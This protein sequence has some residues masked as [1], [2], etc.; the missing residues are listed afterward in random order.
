M[1]LLEL[2]SEKLDAAMND[3]TFSAEHKKRVIEVTQILEQFENFVSI[4]DKNT[5]YDT[6]NNYKMDYRNKINKPFSD[7]GHKDWRTFKHPKQD[8]DQRDVKKN[9]EGNWRTLK[10]DSNVAA[11]IFTRYNKQTSSSGME[12]K[13]RFNF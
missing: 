2:L 12:I 11:R 10:P 9:D 13:S 8:T 7:S 1:N 3:P 6:G 5:N 4:F